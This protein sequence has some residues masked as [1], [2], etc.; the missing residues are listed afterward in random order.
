MHLCHRRPPCASLRVTACFVPVGVPVPGCSTPV[1][2]TL[3]NNC[4]FFFSSLSLFHTTHPL[5]QWSNLCPG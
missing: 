3:A 5:R 4:C 1:Y 2:T